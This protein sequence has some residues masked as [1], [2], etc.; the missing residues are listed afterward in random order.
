MNSSITLRVSE[1]DKELIKSFSKLKKQTVSKFILDTIIER[2]EEEED[3]ELAL[4]HS[5]QTSYK[6]RNIEELANDCGINFY[7]L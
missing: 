6:T 5:K 3:Y 1:E 2:I 7:E 4:L